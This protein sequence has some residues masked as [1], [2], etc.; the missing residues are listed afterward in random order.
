MWYGTVGAYEQSKAQLV[1]FK[2]ICSPKVT[3]ATQVPA[4]TFLAFINNSE[5]FNAGP[6]VL[7][8]SF[9]VLGEEY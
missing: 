8:T 6:Q 5:Y 2:I 3:V 4:G 7:Q 1:I 9:R